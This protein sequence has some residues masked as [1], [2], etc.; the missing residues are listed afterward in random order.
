MPHKV[1][2]TKAAQTNGSER[3]RINGDCDIIDPRQLIDLA[4]MKRVKQL[5]RLIAR[6]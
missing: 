4:E 2:A 3:R 1:K 6:R 5:T